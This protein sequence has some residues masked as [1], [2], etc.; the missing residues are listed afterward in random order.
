MSHEIIS[1]YTVVL[2][3][4]SL[5]DHLK[6]KMYKRHYTNAITDKVELQNI[7]VFITQTSSGHG[8]GHVTGSDTSI[9]MDNKNNR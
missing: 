4:I 2:K 8:N 9:N 5:E 1:I 3:C 7:H 6:I